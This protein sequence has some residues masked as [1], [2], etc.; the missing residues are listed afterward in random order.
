MN[1]S[2]DLT[3]TVLTFLNINEQLKIVEKVKF[4]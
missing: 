4:K 3:E 1:I 2:S